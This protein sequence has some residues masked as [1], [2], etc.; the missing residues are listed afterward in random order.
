M[1][2]STV[3]AMV[4]SK[5]LGGET[6]DFDRWQGRVKQYQE[7]KDTHKLKDC[8]AGDKIDVRDTEYVWCIATVELKIT[9]HNHIPIYYVHYEVIKTNH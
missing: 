1:I 6:E 3:R 9:S 8:K 4:L 5:K 7:W 2:D